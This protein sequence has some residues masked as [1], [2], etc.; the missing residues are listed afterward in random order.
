LLANA[1]SADWDLRYEDLTLPVLV[2][3]GL[4]DHVFLDHD[5]I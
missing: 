1:G 2:M 4:Q 5:R 3:T